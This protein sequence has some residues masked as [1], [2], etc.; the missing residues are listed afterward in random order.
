MAELQ[1]TLEDP[2]KALNEKRAEGEKYLGR[3]G[4]T[5]SAEEPI[6]LY[7][8]AHERYYLVTASLVCR[9]HGLPD[10]AV[11]TTND[12]RVGFV[13][14]RRVPEQTENG[15]QKREYGWFGEERGWHLVESGPPVL[16]KEIDENGSRVTIEEER[17]PMFP[18]NY[19]P[20][21]PQERMKGKR[22][23]WAGLIPVAKRDTFETASLQ[24]EPGAA[25]TKDTSPDPRRTVFETRI[26]QAFKN[27]RDELESATP[28]EPTNVRDRLLFAWLDFWEFLQ[29]YL[30][31]VAQKVKNIDNEAA[32]PADFD[33][34]G[35]E[36]VAL[37][38]AFKT[39]TLQQKIGSLGTTASAILQSVAEKSTKIE[40]GNLDE[41]LPA[42][43]I[44]EFNES[45]EADLVAVLNKILDP[46][47]SE[48][49][50]DEKRP[51]LQKTVSAALSPL[52]GANNVPEHLQPPPAD[53]TTGGT[54]VVRCV[55]ERPNCPPS[56]RVHV[57]TPT[58]SFRLASFFD[59]EAPPRDMN[60]TLPG[61]TTDALRGSPQSV[62][63]HF[64]E[65]LSKQAEDIQE[66]ALKGLGV[67]DGESIDLGRVC[68]LSIPII[69]ICAL[70]LLLIIVV[71]LNVVFW[72]LP[73]FKI[74][75]PLPSSDS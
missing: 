12:E 57:S 28:S 23:L 69:T 3:N 29:K 73:F 46:N 65:E 75:F 66:E 21:T 52:E 70:V 74:C 34:K 64:T 25:T 32:T 18:Q 27:L 67:E 1:T 9:E 15:K 24:P 10:R 63:M 61:I 14:R 56:Q 5:E 43:D 22:R 45:G 6:P 8:P 38:D 47:T 4:T 19:A 36:K 72:W 51:D 55:Y 58:R 17:L 48:D 13:L 54:Y 33:S 53:P 26:I 68:S 62:T 2:K 40:S 31:D 30:P 11:D 60:I 16:E 7:Q 59:A 20:N 49:S 50:L 35:Q 39:L 42:D 71:V 41:V 37:I 44:G